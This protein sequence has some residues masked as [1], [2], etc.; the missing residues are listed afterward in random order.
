M[1]AS[2]K[3]P[4]DKVLSVAR[5][6]FQNGLWF[7]VFRVAFKGSGPESISFVDSSDA[8]RLTGQGAAAVATGSTAAA[9]QL[10][11]ENAS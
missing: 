3:I 4:D 6:C 9:L 10:R 5:I 1:L 8:I 7:K 11:P 2:A